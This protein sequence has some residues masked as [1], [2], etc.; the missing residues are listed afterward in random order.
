VTVV[1]VPRD[2]ANPQGPEPDLLALRA[3]CEYLEPRRVLT[4]EVHVLG[5]RYVDVS[6]SV[7]ID[8][9]P[10]RD[11]APVRDAVERALREFLSPLAGGP[12]GDGWPLDK[13]VEERELWVRAARVDGVSA[14]RGVILWDGDGAERERVPIAGHELPRLRR[15]AV[16]VGDPAETLDEAPPVAAR[17]VPV[18]V[19][20]AAC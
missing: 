15:I 1:V 8:V 14:V 3:V 4:A 10:G 16:R 19:V 5:P 18:P 7:G 2:P 17:R 11:V 13:A 9:L 12:G 20:P 6:L